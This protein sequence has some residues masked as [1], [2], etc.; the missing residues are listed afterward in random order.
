MHTMA[1][2]TYTVHTHTEVEVGATEERKERGRKE[3][4]K[5]EGETKSKATTQ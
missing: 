2:S 5:K 1:H 3:G 4:G